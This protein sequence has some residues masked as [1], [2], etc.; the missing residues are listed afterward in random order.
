MGLGGYNLFPVVNKNSPSHSTHP[1]Q[2]RQ[3]TEAERP[4]QLYVVHYEYVLQ[5]APRT[6]FKN[7]RSPGGVTQPTCCRAQK[8]LKAGGEEEEHQ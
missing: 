1:H 3:Q 5:R 8:K 6:V 2:I 4:V 7:H